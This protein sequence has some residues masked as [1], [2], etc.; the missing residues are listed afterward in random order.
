MFQVQVFDP[1]PEFNRWRDIELWVGDYWEYSYTWLREDLSPEQ[2]E[3]ARHYGF[4]DEGSVPGT[5]AD[6]F[7]VADLIHFHSNG[8]TRTGI[9]DLRTSELI[10]D[11]LAPTDVREHPDFPRLSEAAWVD[12]FRQA[13]G[14]RCK[15]AAPGELETT[16]R[17]LY[18]GECKHMEPSEVVYVIVDQRDTPLTWPLRLKSEIQRGVVPGT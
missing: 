11:S 16:A 7:R 18:A 13:A 5:L 2:R 3:Q 8:Q 17:T 10:Y 14:F 4:S 1:S 15:P 12:A 6:A 9:R